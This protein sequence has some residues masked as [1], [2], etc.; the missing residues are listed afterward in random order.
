MLIIKMDI[1]EKLVTANKL[2]K[3]CI[4]EGYF[5]SVKIFNRVLFLLLER[6]SVSVSN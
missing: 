6:I 4:D 3:T 2:Y 5:R 1:T